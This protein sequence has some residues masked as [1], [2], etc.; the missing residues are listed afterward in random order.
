MCPS[1][2]YTIYTVSFLLGRFHPFTGHEGP[3]ESSG[4][5]LSYF[6]PRHQKGVRGQR[7]APA[8]PYP[9]ERPGTHCIGGWVGLRAGL[10]WCGKSRPTGIRSPDRPARRQSLY[11]LSYPAH[12]FSFIKFKIKEQIGLPRSVNSSTTALVFR[13]GRHVIECYALLYLIN[14]EISYFLYTYYVNSE[15]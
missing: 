8:A 9:R 12:K 5:A 2:P 7:H 14:I 10:D 6:I 15:I 1:A 13:V 3:R 4:I 11:R